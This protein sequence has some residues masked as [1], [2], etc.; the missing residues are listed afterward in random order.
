MKPSNHIGSPF[1]FLPSRLSRYRWNT[2]VWPTCSPATLIFSC[3]VIWKCS[4]LP[5]P[6]CVTSLITT[7]WRTQ[8]PLSV[9]PS[10]VARLATVPFT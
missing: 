2:Y 3:P 10:T 8:C 1:L 4:G 6:F 7:S 5:G 9:S